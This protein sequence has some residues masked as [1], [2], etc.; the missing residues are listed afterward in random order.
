MIQKNSD[1]SLS[2]LLSFIA[3]PVVAI[4]SCGCIMAANEATEKYTGIKLDD[5]VGSNLFEQ[6]IFDASLTGIIKENLK[7]RLSG[8]HIEPYEVTIKGKNG[9]VTNFFINAKKIVQNNQ[10]LD[11][12]VFHDIITVRERMETKVKEAEKLYLAMFEQTPFGVLVIDPETNALLEFNDTAHRQLGYT[13]EEFSKLHTYDIEAT[14]SL[15][16]IQEKHTQTLKEGQIEFLTKHRTK[17]GETRM[18]LVNQRKIEIYGKAVLLC[19]CHDVTGV[20]QMQDALRNSEEKFYGITNSV[21][22]ALILVDEESKVTYWNPAAEKTFGYTNK[23]AT[24]KKIHELVVPRSMPAEG[25]KRIRQS[26]K[27]FSETGMGYFTI[28]NVELVGRRKNGSEFP[29]ELTLAPIKLNGQWHAVGVVKDV[30]KRKQADQKL[31]EAEQRYHAL[32]NQSPIGVLVVD[33]VTASCI[34]FNDVAHLQLGYTREEFESIKIFDIEAKES[35]EETRDH[36]KNLA[37]SGGQEFETRQRTKNGETRDVIVTT[38][39]FQSDDGRT[40]L[41]C[42]FHDITEIRKVQNALMESEARYRQLVELAQEGIWAINNDFTTVFVNPRMAQILGYKESDMLGKQLF[43][44]IDPDMVETIRDIIVGFTRRGMKG[45][46][47]YAFPHKNGGHVDTTITLSIINDDQKRKI[48]TLAVVSDITQRKQAERA[49]KASEELSRAIVANAPIGIATTDSSYHFVTANEAF[50][51]ILG[52]TEAELRKLTFKNLSHPE[53]IEESA[54]N[55]HTLEKGENPFFVEA[56]HYIKKD[57]SSI[58]GRVIVS[59]IRNPKGQ[60]ILFVIE[61][62]DIT[63]R[64]QLQDD[65]QSSEER[66]RAIST[67]AMD[68]IVLCDAKDN[69]L[70]WNPAAEKTFGF[71]A[72]QAIGKK[73]ADLVIPPKEHRKHT[74]YLSQLD[75]SLTSKRLFGLTA[76]RKDGTSFPIDLS[77]VTVKVNDQNCSLS[78]IRDITEWKAMEEALRQERDLLDSVAASTDACIAIINRDYR[79]VWGNQRAR[80]VGLCKDIDNKHCYSVFTTGS[81]VCQGCG[82]KKVLENGASL[83]RHDYHGQVGGQDYWLELIATPMRDKDGNVVAAL[84][85]AIDITVRKRLQNKLG[86]YSLKLEELVQ[87]RTEQLK[88][89]QAE[90][91]KSERLAAIGELAGMI[92]HD[93]RNP[94]S[95][96][97]NSAYF[98]KKKGAD[99]SPNQAR[100]MLEIIDK[101]VDYSNRIINDLLDYSKELHLTLEETSPRK[102]LND[103]LAMIDIPDRIKVENKLSDTPVI[104]ADPDKAKRVVINLVKNAVDAMPEGGKITVDGKEAKGCLEISF[105]DTGIGISDDVMPRLFSPLFTTKDKGM[106]FGLAICKRIIEAHGGTITVKTAKGQGTT[107][108]VTFPIAP[109][110][111]NGGETHG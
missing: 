51:S 108:A 24:G 42:I 84:E 16:K 47:D 29:A 8:I 40:Y 3:D 89:T 68:A 60:P 15:E 61:L 109:K 110:L 2:T 14:G 99:L 13:R 34:E 93:L 28:G 7:K 50:C 35:N 105:A 88:K 106:G 104:K 11:V 98:M 97:K 74:E 67:S 111:E 19:T 12:I 22:D 80:Q 21:K 77:R 83:D 57:G 33:P 107:F 79:I 75:T 62:E 82:V 26:V 66:F 64:K 76:L 94:L 9:K 86:E 101:C 44:F 78:I 55:I 31:R 71:S 17:N 49:L 38:R 90:L 46:Y 70:Y 48:G 59:A 91:V 36:L 102:L 39:P 100:E 6:G 32:F 18:V 4:D 41:H 25:R 63:K 65:L 95:G 52:Y 69:V 43:D 72:D 45:Q 5:L 92:G 54:Q 87:K 27:T 103:S 56:K 30:S 58:V 10:V 1:S 85:V 81:E 37:E 20:N 96:I 23:E 73:L 53:E